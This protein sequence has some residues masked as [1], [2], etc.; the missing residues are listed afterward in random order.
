MAYTQK[1]T[2]LLAADQA[3]TGSWADLG[4][5][6]N[7]QDCA[8]VALAFGL[9]VNDAQNV[10]VRALA[11]NAEGGA[12]EAMFPIKVTASTE[13]KVTAHYYELDTDA[14]QVIFLDWDLKRCVNAIQFQV[15]AGTAGATA[16][17]VL[18]ATTFYSMGV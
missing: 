3:I 11:V 10:R 14:D 12:S 13:V 18:A 4:A 1:P 15:I 8:Y 7:V 5:E 9:D 16:G 2:A 17:K 6:I